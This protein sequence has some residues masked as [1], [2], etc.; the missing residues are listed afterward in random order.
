MSVHLNRNLDWSDNTD[1]I[2]KKGQCRLHLL[3]RLASFGVCRPLLRPFFDSVVASVV[4]YAVVCWVGGCSEW[5][6]NR[7]KKD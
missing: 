7:L 4:S 5:D 2:Y 3:R 1:S 6:K